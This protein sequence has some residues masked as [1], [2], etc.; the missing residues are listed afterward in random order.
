MLQPNV[1]QSLSKTYTQICSMDEEGDLCP[2][3][4]AILIGLK[5][6]NSNLD[7]ETSI[8]IINDTCKSKAC[9]ESTIEFYKVYNTDLFNS[10]EDLSYT[11]GSYT[12]K[13][14]S[15]PKE[16][17]ELLESKECQSKQVMKAP[18]NVKTDDN[19]DESNAITNKI[20]VILLVSLMFMSLMVFH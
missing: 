7:D 6:G 16:L 8:Q 20:N 2:F 15:A 1:M 5:N 13:E 4:K 14:M 12:Y 17:I 11:E 19:D 18:A 3:A 10:L 9:T